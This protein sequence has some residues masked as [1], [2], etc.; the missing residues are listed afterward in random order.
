MAISADLTLRGIDL[1]GAY[2]K[3]WTPQLVEIEREQNGEKEFYV[4][5]QVMVWQS[6]EKRQAG[7]VPLPWQNGQRQMAPYDISAALNPYEA[8][9]KHLKMAS[10]LANARDV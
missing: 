1:T 4:A 3:V 9:Y 10:E 2:L 6:Q 7:V 8:A 5:Y